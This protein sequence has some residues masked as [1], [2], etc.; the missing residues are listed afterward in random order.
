M[1]PFIGFTCS[2]CGKNYLPGEVVYTC[3]TDGGNLDV[4]LDYEAIKRKYHIEDITCRQDFSLW[5]Y[6]PLLPVTDP[7]GEGTPL[8]MAG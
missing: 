6:L 7:G 8:R 5:R 1:E 4:N 3:P 2:L